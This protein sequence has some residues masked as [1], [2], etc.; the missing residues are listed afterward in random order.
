MPRVVKFRIAVPLRV[1]LTQP[2][3][4]W[5]C[6]QVHCG[7]PAIEKKVEDKISQLY[8]WVERHPGKKAQVRRLSGAAREPSRG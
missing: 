1:C 6:L 4:L 7:D 8:S 2:Y 3:Q 5:L